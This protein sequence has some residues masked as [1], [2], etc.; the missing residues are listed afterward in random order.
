MS[1]LRRVLK[2]RSTEHV[3]TF[4]VITVVKASF[5]EGREK[6]RQA[7]ADAYI[8]MHERRLC[9]YLEFLFFQSCC[10]GF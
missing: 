2:F 3:V 8:R 1:T 6:A 9:D 7:L 5:M 4:S 10:Q